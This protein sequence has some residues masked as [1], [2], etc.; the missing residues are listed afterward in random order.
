MESSSTTTLFMALFLDIH[1]ILAYSN[2]NVNIETHD[3]SRTA[4]VAQLVTYF[5]ALKEV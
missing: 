5:L 1:L 4:A 3:L 2:S